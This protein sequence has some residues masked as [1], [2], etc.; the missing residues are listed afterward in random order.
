M[1]RNLRLGVYSNAMVV[2]LEFYIRIFSLQTKL[3]K[4]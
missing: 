1:S 3:R 4:A 2:G